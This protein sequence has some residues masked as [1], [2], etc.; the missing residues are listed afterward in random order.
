MKVA[1][2]IN[3]SGFG[4]VE[5]RFSMFIENS[6]FD[7][8]IIC[9]S[10]KI[11]DK[12]SN[13]FHDKK[14]I[15]ANRVLNN[16]DVKYPTA[17]RKKVLVSKINKLQPDV[18]VIWDF[19]PRIDLSKIKCK[20]IYY[21]CGCGWR[22]PK[23]T[24]TED[25]FKN[26]D[27]VISNSNAS[28]R[29]IQLRYNFNKDIKVVLNKLNM[30]ISP[31]PRNKPDAGIVLGTASRLVGI[32]GIGISILTVKELLDNGVNAFLIIAGDGDNREEL[33]RLTESLSLQNNIMF[34]GYQ[35]DLTD[36]YEE[37]DIYLSTPV[38]EA[39]GL[40]CIEAMS[41]GIPVIYPFIDGQPEA[42]KNG[43]SGIAI[44]PTLLPDE[45]KEKTKI[46][47]DFPYDVYNPT[48][49]K[50]TSIKLI[51]PSD[52][53]VAIQHVVNNYH[54]LSQNALTWSKNTMDFPFFINEFES[55]IANS[56]MKENSEP[57]QQLTIHNI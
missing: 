41:H 57:L 5:K 55:A 39:F 10:N 20:K 17:L 28:K 6:H 8:T 14:I 13:L 33:E 47:I 21:D 52:C 45:Y 50:L 36:F 48:D 25:F 54:E 27:S 40:S 24:K 18:L 11:D 49:D 38:T 4:G 12:I 37:I 42:I 19:M 23:N 53:R 22:Y 32:K 44:K 9:C 2:L 7:N 3:L 34:I 1:H 30:P 51:S 31:E 43:Y 16:F 35:S 26:I 29:I 15:F 46:T 56:V